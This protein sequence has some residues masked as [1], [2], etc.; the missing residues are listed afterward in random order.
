MTRSVAET[1]DALRILL[2]VSIFV[3]LSDKGP[4][5]ASDGPESERQGKNKE[6]L[7][8]RRQR[9]E[10]R[11]TAAPRQHDGKD[12]AP[13]EGQERRRDEGDGR[14]GVSYVGPGRCRL[15]SDDPE[16][17]EIYKNIKAKGGTR[18]EIGP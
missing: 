10:D 17:A 18:K 13:L 1:A 4:R 15:K 2:P 14:R 3:A 7:E 6:I 11:G 5:E 9:R 12:A 8:G 16:T